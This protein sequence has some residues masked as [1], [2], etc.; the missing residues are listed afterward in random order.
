MSVEIKKIEDQE[1]GK[2]DSVALPSDRQHLVIKD[3]I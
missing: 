2:P 3:I 1:T